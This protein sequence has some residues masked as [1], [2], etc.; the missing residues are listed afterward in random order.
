MPP[1]PVGGQ[2]D[3]GEGQK[4][5][6][7]VGKGVREGFFGVLPIPGPV[8]AALS[9]RP[10]SNTGGEGGEGERG[11]GGAGLGRGHPPPQW[12]GHPK[13]E[14]GGSKPPPRVPFFTFLG[15][16]QPQ[17]GE[18]EKEKKPSFQFWVRDTPKMRREGRGGTNFS[19][20]PSPE[21]ILGVFFPDFLIFWGIFHGWK[22]LAGLCTAQSGRNSGVGA[23]IQGWGEGLEG[24]GGLGRTPQHSNKRKIPKIWSAGRGRGVRGA[25]EGI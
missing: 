15:T 16:G 21:G 19:S 18:G 10:G 1:T 20:P 14:E 24:S 9:A 11:R 12:R 7:G 13:N 8:P 5:R 4:D 3:A 2:R 23:G 6:G 22:K 25:G 17:N